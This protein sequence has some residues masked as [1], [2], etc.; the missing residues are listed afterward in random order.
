MQ[1]DLAKGEAERYPANANRVATTG[2]RKI[3]LREWATMII[4]NHTC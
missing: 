3:T 4:L 1:G 2:C